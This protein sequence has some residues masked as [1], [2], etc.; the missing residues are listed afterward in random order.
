MRGCDKGFKLPYRNDFSHRNKIQIFLKSKNIY[1]RFSEGQLGNGKYGN[2]DPNDGIDGP[3]YGDDFF[4]PKT[5]HEYS[6]AG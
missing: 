5:E 4:T 2:F 6:N 3:L 1:A